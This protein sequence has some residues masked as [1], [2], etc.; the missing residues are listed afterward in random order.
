MS[1]NEGQSPFFDEF[2]DDYFAESDTHLTSIRSNLLSLES[3]LDCILNQQLT[4]EIKLEVKSLV[5]ELLRSFHTL[6]GLSGMVGIKEAEALAHIMESYLR[7]IREEQVSLSRSAMEAFIVGVKV[8]EETIAARR[9]KTE[10]PDISVIMGQIAAELPGGGRE[11]EEQRSRGAEEQRSRGA[12]E[13]VGAIPPRSPQGRGD[14]EQV[15]AI[16]PW[17]PQGRGDEE[18]SLPRTGAQAHR[19]TSAPPQESPVTLKPDELQR[20]KAAISKG[21]QA[22]HVEFTPDRDRAER[23]INVNYVRSRL[24]EIG[25]LIHAA[26]RLAPGGKTLFDFVVATTMARENLFPNPE[27]DGISCCLFA[28]PGI[29]GSCAEEPRSREDEEQVGAI[30]PWSPQRPGAEELSLPRSPAQALPSRWRA[31]QIRGDHGGIAP[32]SET[33]FEDAEDFEAAEVAP[34][35]PSET[36]A[37]VRAG[38]KSAPTVMPSNVVRVDLAR[39]DDLMRMLGE[40]V[41]SRARLEDQLARLQSIVP[42]KHLRPIRETSQTLERQL[43]D[44]RQGVMR[45]R[46]VPIGQIFSR[47]QFVVRDVAKAT[48]KQVRLELKGEETEIDKYVVE[49]LM[50]P[51]LHIVRNAISHGLESESDRLQAGKPAQG[52]LALRAATSGEMVILEIEDDGRGVDVNRVTERARQMGVLDV[53]AQIDLIS[54]LDILCLSGFSTKEQADLTSGRGVGLAVV[55]NTV[56]ELGGILSLTTA[57]GRGTKFT[58]ELPLTLAIADAL[59]VSVGGQT[60]AVP[61]SSVREVIEVESHKITTLEN[62]DNNTGHAGRGGS[63]G[64][65]DVQR[66]F[67]ELLSFRQDVLPLRR[68]AH[69]FGLSQVAQDRFH[70]VIIGKDLNTVGIIVDRIIGRREIV[71]QPLSD[72]LIQVP[73]LAGATELG[74][75]RVVLIL[76]VAALIRLS[77]DSE[78]WG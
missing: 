6:K 50:D 18:P 15:G 10:P 20:L 22:W 36:A 31:T 66:R 73:G 41:I 11:A 67:T 40:L 8:L 61:E 35:Q 37:A 47:M 71:V 14:E 16:P 19:R 29:E 75:G 65:S 64:L 59:I 4:S 32:T 26:P 52:H 74:D 45:V 39:L 63:Q 7:A 46:L 2:L 53:E 68:L 58:I 70:A 34:V 23:G 42:T 12:E 60:F 1:D 44:L 54:L 9:T 3:L 43:R 13:Q 38:L 57:P 69:L 5:D 56:Q 49:R 30:P 24:Q 76:D 28:I 48:H 72:P 78:K 55:K 25:D 51:L 17:L 27:Q 21:S 62:W 77:K 33:Q